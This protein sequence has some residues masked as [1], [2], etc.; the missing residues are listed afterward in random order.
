MI[1]EGEAKGRLLP[2]VYARELDNLVVKGKETSIEEGNFAA[3]EV[4]ENRGVV[5]EGF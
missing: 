2:L 1:V 4:G 3:E 5:Q